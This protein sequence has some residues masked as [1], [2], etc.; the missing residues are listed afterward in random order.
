VSAGFSG[1]GK[2]TKAR[3]FFVGALI[4]A[5]GS[6]YDCTRPEIFVH[7]TAFRDAGIGPIDILAN[8]RFSYGTDANARRQ[9]CHSQPSSG[10]LGWKAIRSR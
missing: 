8:D 3:T 4:S 1:K 10:G 6:S 5:Y 7:A 9:I 2:K